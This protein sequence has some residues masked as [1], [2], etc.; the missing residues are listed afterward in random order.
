MRKTWL[1]LATLFSF[2]TAF[3]QNLISNCS[4]ENYTIC[5]T[6]YSQVPYATGWF[7]LHG[8]T[9]DLINSCN[10]GTIVG[11]PTNTFGVEDAAHGQGYAGGYSFT[12]ILSSGPGNDYKEYIATTIAALTPGVP[13]E[14][15]MSI[16]LGDQSGWGTD[17]IGAM[18]FVSTPSF[19]STYYGSPV[20]LNPGMQTVS[21]ASYGAITDTANWVRVTQTFI[22][23]SAYTVIA[24][25]SLHETYAM[26][27]I[28]SAGGPS[29]Y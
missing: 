13:Y 17:D 26:G 16:A 6:V 8:G 23:D 9:S 3:A 12:N 25:G 29:G 10:G 21:Y 22:P 28:S 27:T 15:S 5:P 18:F 2:H 19:P 14:L 1:V 24:I 20:T 11:V 4:F 7:P